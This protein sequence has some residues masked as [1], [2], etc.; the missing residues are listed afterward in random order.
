MTLLEGQLYID[1][2]DVSSQYGLYVKD[3]GLRELLQWPQFKT[4]SIIM[5]DWHES[6]GIE[7]D[8]SSPVLDGR[9]F[10]LQFHIAHPDSPSDAQ[11]LLSKLTSRVYHSFHF[12]FLG[13]SYTLRLVSNPSFAQNARFDTLT[14]TFAE[15]AVAVPASSGPSSEA[16]FSTGYFLDGTDFAFYGCHVVMGTRDSLLRFAQP[17]ESLRRSFSNADGIVY[18]GG[19]TVRLKT[20]DITVNL[21]M[22]TASVADFWGKWNALWYAVLCIDNDARNV[23]DRAVRIVEGDGMEFRCFYKSNTVT[24]F[25]PLDNGG[26]WCDFSIVLTCLDYQPATD[27][28]LLAAEDGAFIITENESRIIAKSL[29]LSP[30]LVTENGESIITEDGVYRICIDNT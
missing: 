5:Q 22:R 23:T 7:A 20:R 28:L 12:P 29:V 11:A 25:V 18:D 4:S 17:K 8:L 30:M 2:A 27:W 15:D 14:L 6:D 10:R 16:S 19:D 21:H 26:V 9:Q 3:D 1:G 13:K 24:R